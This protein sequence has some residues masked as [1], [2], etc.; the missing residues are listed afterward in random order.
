MVV[1]RLLCEQEFWNQEGHTKTRDQ[2]QAFK[3][4]IKMD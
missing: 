2:L 4:R 1:C 3:F